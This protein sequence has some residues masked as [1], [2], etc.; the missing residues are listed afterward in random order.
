M[1]WLLFIPHLFHI[2]ILRSQKIVLDNSLKSMYNFSMKIR[3]LTAKYSSHKGGRHT[4]AKDYNRQQ[5]KQETKQMSEKAKSQNSHI[6]IVE[7]L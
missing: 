7:R 1:S 5:L 4:S 6:S 3:N 2:K